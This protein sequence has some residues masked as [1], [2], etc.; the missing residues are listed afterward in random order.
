MES[1]S[2]GCYG[3]VAR[4][5]SSR[6]LGITALMAVPGTVPGTIPD[7]V[8]NCGDCV[9]YLDSTSSPGYIALLAKGINQ[10]SAST[11]AG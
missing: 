11:T 10:V 5:S 1:K 6:I 7:T 8:I 4:T 2:V 3:D 9:E